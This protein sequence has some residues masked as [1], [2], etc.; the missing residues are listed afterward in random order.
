[1]KYL[2][3]GQ[4]IENEQNRRLLKMLCERDLSA[5][6]GQI[7]E[8][9]CVRCDR[10]H[11]LWVDLNGMSGFIPRCEA[12]VGVDDGSTREIAVLS[13]VGRPVCFMAVGMKTGTDGSEMFILSRRAAQE[14]ALESLLAKKIGDVVPAAVTSI[15]PFG[16]FVDLG[17]GIVSMIGIENISVSRIRSP[18]ERFSIGDSIYAVITGFSNDRIILSHRE[19]LG[20]WKENAALFTAGE[21]VPGIVRGVRDYGVFVELTPNLSGLAEYRDDLPEGTP[22]SVNIKSIIPERRKVKLVVIDTLPS[23]PPRKLRYFV[24][25][26]NVAGWEY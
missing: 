26:G 22:V 9:N 3:E 14:M 4:L 11:N 1:M 17:C 18:A 8:A 23:L 10:E 7:M 15:A 19:L 5:V 12:A 13:R 20:T 16:V 6:D 21:T 24:T 25:E 2:P